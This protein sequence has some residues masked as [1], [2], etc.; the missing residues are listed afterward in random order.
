MSMHGCSTQAPWS[1]A[2]SV[3]TAQGELH[4][5]DEQHRLLDWSAGA[6]CLL[7]APRILHACLTGSL[8]S[9][10]A[11]DGRHVPEEME[12]VGHLSSKAYR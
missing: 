10:T 2:A 12:L 8:S 9:P 6:C 7:H 11:T 5:S 4:V 3:P 1:M